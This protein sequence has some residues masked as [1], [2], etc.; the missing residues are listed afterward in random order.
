MATLFA[1]DIG[2]TKSELAIFPLRGTDNVS[3]S[4]KRYTNAEFSGV[5]AILEHFLAQL[6]QVPQFACLAVAGVVTDDRAKLTNLPWE[7]D[8]HQLEKRFGFQQV[9]L[10]NDLTA[11]CSSLAVLESADLLEIQA[12]ESPGGEVR[13]VV[14]PGTG[15]GEGLLVEFGGQVFACGSEGGH[16]DFAPVDEEQLALLVWM[17][18]KIQPVSYEALIAGPGL[19]Y[20]YD[21]CREHHHIR[22]SA[23]IVEAMSKA[24]DRIPVIVGGAIGSIG[25]T[26]DKPCPLCRRVI[27][28]FLSI[29]GS[30]AGNLALKLYARGGVY[31]GGGILP[32]LAG[33][34]TFDGFLK[35]FHAKG[36]MSDLMKDIPVYLILRKDAALIGAVRFAR[37]ELKD[38]SS[39]GR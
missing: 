22:E 31:L 18:K 25:A 32:R 8:C 26:G 21:F 34:V 11:V 20:L 33:R 12:G 15:L 6:D 23:W 3:L 24:K 5:E 1:A 16:T 36:L 4:Q 38:W 13:G 30:E 19:S 17:Q 28:L 14:A 9:V 2:G 7:I 35:S 27:D 37:Q 10:L 39:N 29:L